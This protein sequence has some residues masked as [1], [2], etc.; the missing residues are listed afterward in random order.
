MTRRHHYNLVQLYTSRPR[1]VHGLYRRPDLGGVLT[2]ELVGR[3][4][5]RGWGLRAGEAHDL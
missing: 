4:P 3:G 2:V 5:E 1:L